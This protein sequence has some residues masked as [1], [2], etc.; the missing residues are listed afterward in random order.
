MYLTDLTF[1]EDGSSSVGSS[2]GLINFRKRELISDVISDLQSYQNIPYTFKEVSVIQDY[3]NNVD[4]L[5]EGEY[6]KLSLEREAQ[7]NRNTE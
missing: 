2:V 3:L 5:N 7:V 4:T 6:Y 1:I